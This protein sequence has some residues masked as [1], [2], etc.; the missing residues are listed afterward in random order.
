VVRA[1]SRLCGGVGECWFEKV[2]FAF[3]GGQGQ[4]AEETLA[5]RRTSAAVCGRRFCGTL[6]TPLGAVAAR[7]K[8]ITFVACA[9][10][11]R[12]IL[13]IHIFSPARKCRNEARKARGASK[14]E[15]APLREGGEAVTGPAIK[16]QKGKVRRQRALP[17][18]RKPAAR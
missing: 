5:T 12:L 9:H 18:E 1:P 3:G 16:A 6:L 11:A 10:K 13:A 17:S 8:M 14:P 15:A 4:F 7:L 2:G